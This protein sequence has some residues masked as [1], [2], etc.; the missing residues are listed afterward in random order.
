[1]TTPVTTNTPATTITDT[2]DERVAHHQPPRPL[3]PPA[4][5]QERAT[6]RGA[7][8]QGTLSRRGSAPLRL[9][10]GF[11]FI[12]LVLSFFGARL[13]QLQGVEPAKYATLAASTGGTVTVEL[14]AQRGDIFDRNGRA[15]AESVAG[16]MV[17]ADP[18]QTRAVAPQ[19][20][21][22]LA[23][24]LPIDYFNTLHALSQQDTRFAYIARRVPADQA[25]RVV[26][27]A[28][29]A[30]YKGLATRN[31]PLR[32]YPDHDVASNLV[33]FMGTDGPLAGL[34]LSFNKQ[35]AGHGR[36]RDLRG[37]SR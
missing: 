11:L 17:V 7:A 18:L 29:Q 36:L 9:R 23:K 27:E 8:G 24:R 33:G 15:L 25:I 19:L 31:D 14:P 5:Q 35:L 30:G 12:A 1:M 21:R 26:N 22:F 32:S 20:A 28:T 34:E 10:T 2:E 4:L 6:R 37:R 3:R 16:R 13:I